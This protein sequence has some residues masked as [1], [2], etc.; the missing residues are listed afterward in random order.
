MM[1]YFIITVGLIVVG[2]EKGE[3]GG[4]LFL[5]WEKLHPPN[6]NNI[7]FNGVYM[8]AINIENSAKIT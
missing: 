1:K 6:K 5:F 2:G 7:I 4:D 8:L 3:G